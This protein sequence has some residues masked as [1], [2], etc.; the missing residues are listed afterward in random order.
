MHV[1]SADRRG[2]TVQLFTYFL[3]FNEESV[4]VVPWIV[5]VQ[6]LLMTLHLLT[7]EVAEDIRITEHFVVRTRQVLHQ[8]RECLIQ[9]VEDSS[10]WE[11]I[12]F[13]SSFIFCDKLWAKTLATQSAI[14]P[15]K[16]IKEVSLWIIEQKNWYCWLTIPHTEPCIRNDSVRHLSS[17]LNLWS[18]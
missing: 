11:K 1:G 4:D 14:D 6:V 2:Y 8:T 12:S 18:L 3:H 10:R 13:T 5:V 15:H 17:I 16:S 7:E 9:L